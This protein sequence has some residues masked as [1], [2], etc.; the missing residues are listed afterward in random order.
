MDLRLAPPNTPYTTGEPTKRCPLPSQPAPF[1]PQS[2]LPSP[3]TRTSVDV[4]AHEEVV[5]RGAAQ[6]RRQGHLWYHS[7]A[8]AQVAVPLTVLGLSPPM[9]NSSSRSL[10]WPWMSPP[11]P[12]DRQA[13]CPRDQLDHGTSYA[14]HNQ[15]LLPK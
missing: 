8:P 15:V 7:E 5:L 6:G 11:V 9:R 12:A 4:V 3:V 13:A 14:R 10:N 2:S 1:Q